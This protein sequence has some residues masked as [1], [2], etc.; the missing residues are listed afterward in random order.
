VALLLFSFF[1]D[2][3]TISSSKV[4]YLVPLK[5]L[6]IVDKVRVAWIVV[7]WSN[8][9]LWIALQDAGE[10]LQWSSDA[11]RY[12]CKLRLWSRGSELIWTHGIELNMLQIHIS[13]MNRKLVFIVPAIFGGPF[14]ISWVFMTWF[15]IYV[16]YDFVKVNS[17]SRLAQG[18]PNEDPYAA[19]ASQ[20]IALKS[21]AIQVSHTFTRG[22]QV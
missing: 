20:S 6:Q 19:N 18:S 17:L 4:W 7:F 16:I 15:L 9:I 10:S 14:F 8:E 21:S 11:C 12:F 13:L 2:P 1:S 22:G 3:E 5:S